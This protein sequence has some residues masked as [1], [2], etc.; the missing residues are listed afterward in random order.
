MF[1][2]NCGASVPA[3]KFCENCGSPLPDTQST[4]PI[5]QP[6]Q[7]KFDLTPGVQPTEPVSDAALGEQPTRRVF[8]LSPDV[9]AEPASGE[10]PTRRVFDLSPDAQP[11][12]PV[13][14]YIFAGVQP[15]D[16]MPQ[17]TEPVSSYVAEVPGDSA[18]QAQPQQ[19]YQTSQTTQMPPQVDMGYTPSSG[20]PQPPYQQSSTYHPPI[21][22]KAPNTAFVLAIVGLIF[23]VLFVT[24]IPGLVCCIVALVLNAGYN[25]KGLNNPHKTA[26]TVMG[27][28]GIVIAV[29]CLAFSIAVGVLTAQMLDEAERQGIDLAT[30]NVQ[31]TT[32]SEGN[33]KLTVTDSKSSASATDTTSKQSSS[34]AEAS[35]SAASSGSA[36]S[37]AS[38][39]AGAILNTAYEDAKF[40]DANWNPTLYSLVELSGAE[41]TD[42][43]ESYNFTW[44]DEYYGWVAADGSMFAVSG[45]TGEYSKSQ[46]EKMPKGTD[47]LV[48]MGLSVT[49]YSTP[50]SAFEALSNDVTVED[51]YGYEDLY[52]GIIRNSASN[53]YLA[54]VAED[55]GDQ[56]ILLFPENSIT[57]G[58]FEELTGVDAG[59]S[60]NDVWKFITGRSIVSA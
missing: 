6:T 50:K 28:I 18:W 26:T 36:A 56:M 49:G 43:L 2:P 29:L 33:P 58:F 16:E 9:P 1:C 54:V 55:D 37:S 60:V 24:F 17:V 5:E 52:V 59:S 3:T 39:A 19:A 41:L 31:V 15:T 27:V 35:S 13:S 12:E 25:K 14:D 47:G 42:L 32:D 45:I 7:S 22:G 48:V 21:G 51:S 8:D 11:T 30:E 34:A 44:D 23:S 57:S 10:Q 46:I 38:A 40:H 53:R 4:T 20:A